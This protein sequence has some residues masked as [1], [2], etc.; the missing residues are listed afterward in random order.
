MGRL[1]SSNRPL[2]AIIHRQ[3]PSWLQRFSVSPLRVLAS[4][5]F[6]LRQPPLPR[7]SP[8]SIKVVCISDTHNSQQQLPE[9]DLLIHAGDLTQSGTKLEMQR[10]LDWLKKQPHKFKIVVAGNH[11]K[12]LFGAARNSKSQSIDA[13]EWGS[14]IYLED[15]SVEL[16]FDNGRIMKVYGS[17]WSLQHGSWVFQFASHERFFTGKVPC[18]TDILVTHGPPQY[19][20]DGEGLGDDSLMQ[21]V[22]KV[23]PILHVFGHVHAGHGVCRLSYDSFEDSYRDVMAGVYGLLNVVKMA[24]TL[25]LEKLGLITPTKGKKTWL[26]NA[27]VVG[28]ARDNIIRKPQ[29]VFL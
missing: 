8:S 6:S 12:A 10:A 1:W 19:Y 24:A 22:R 25:A 4:T 18:D 3:Q 26:V 14:I 11:D 9:G 13:L 21:E 29:I 17:P 20:L 16:R 23:K 15:T 5:I 28:G 7:S 2:D 27:S